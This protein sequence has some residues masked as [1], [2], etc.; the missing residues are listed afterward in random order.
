MQINYIYGMGSGNTDDF[1]DVSAEVIE[2][3]KELNDLC[4]KYDIVCFSVT[5]PNKYPNGF[6]SQYYFYTTD[7]NDEEYKR[8]LERRD[9]MLDCFN[10]QIYRLTNGEYCISKNNERN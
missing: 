4:K 9:K 6:F 2:K 8:F 10:A 3:Q 7:P 1:D 5:F